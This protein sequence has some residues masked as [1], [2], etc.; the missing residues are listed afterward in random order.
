MKGTLKINIRNKYIPYLE[1]IYRHRDVFVDDKDEVDYCIE[2]S[3]G[4]FVSECED[5]HPTISENDFYHAISYT[6]EVLLNDSES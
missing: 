6:V 4:R 5:L 1:M 2:E 3:I